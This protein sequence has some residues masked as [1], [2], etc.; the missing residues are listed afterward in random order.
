[1]HT[2]KSAAATFLVE[3]FVAHVGELVRAVHRHRQGHRKDLL[4]QARDRCAGRGEMHMQVADPGALHPAAEHQ[5]LGEMEQVAQ[6]RARVFQAPAQR[7][8]EPATVAPGV[9]RE[10]PDLRGHRAT[11]A[12]GLE[13]VGGFA[14]IALLGRHRGQWSRVRVDA[15]G[16]NLEPAL[17][18]AENLAQDEG[19][20]GGG[21]LADEIG[22]ARC[23]RS[24]LFGHGSTPVGCRH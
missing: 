1:M 12:V 5:G 11:Q 9:A 21:V 3:V 2:T 22:D 10:D 18:Q 6:R 16:G 24:G 17:A 23:R 19:V 14:L 7:R 4:R 20:R 13:H 15:R 8:S